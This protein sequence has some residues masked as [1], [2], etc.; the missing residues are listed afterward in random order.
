MPP[1]TTVPPLRVA[2][3][4]AGT[5]PPTGAKRIAASSASRRR[6]VGAAR[7]VRAEILGETLRGPVARPREGV[8]LAALVPR[9]LR[10]DVRR[11]AETVDAEMLRL[12]GHAQR[13][14]ADQPG[15]EQRR[16]LDVGV[17]VRDRE[18]EAGI[19]QRVVRI[20]AVEGVAGESREVAEVLAAGAAIGAGAAGGAEPGNA[21]AV[22]DRERRHAG[23][24][25]LDAADDL[26][27]GHD[28]IAEIGKLAIHDVK[29]G[30]AN[31]ARRDAHQNLSGAGL[32]RHALSQ[33]QRSAAA[34]RAPS[35]SSAHRQLASR[36]GPGMSFSIS[37]ETPP[38][39][40]S[41]KRECP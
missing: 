22:A 40:R 1:Q 12:A 10:H 34:P 31:A 41:R 5:R 4:A 33:P 29:V 20:A 25:R 3:S 11:R 39:I 8:D 30:A 16:G 6:L 27:T 23:P 35:P 32:G 17:E 2:A 26:V 14:V 21:D 15:A 18:D 9:H 7:P 13:A 19:R 28:R 38:R 24:D 36:S 37:R